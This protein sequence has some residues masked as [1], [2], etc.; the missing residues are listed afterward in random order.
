[1][2]NINK[3]KFL[4]DKY[5]DG[6]L[7]RAY[8]K[9]TKLKPIRSMAPPTHIAPNAAIGPVY[10]VPLVIGKERVF[11]EQSKENNRS[12][13]LVD[14]LTIAEMERGAT[15]LHFNYLTPSL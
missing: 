9:H 14:R 12:K 1:M 8:N 7:K 2:K 3:K 10:T 4:K 5:S 13:V 15:K 11:R 6:R